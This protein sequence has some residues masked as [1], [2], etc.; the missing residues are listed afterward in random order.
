[1]NSNSYEIVIIGAGPGGIALA[2]ELINKGMGPDK[3]LVLEKANKESWV[4][5]EL[6]PD[7]KLVTANYKGLNPVAKGIMS[8][9]DMSKP[10]ALKALRD[11]IE[12]HNINVEYDTFVS[13]VEKDGENFNVYTNSGIVYCRFAAIGIG[14]FG[15]PNKPGYPIPP[16]IKA[17]TQFDIT[18][19]KIKDANVLVVGGGDSASEYVQHLAMA[20]NRL[21]IS[22][23]QN[24]FSYMNE[25][26]REIMNEM[27]KSDRLIAMRGTDIDG[28]EAFEGKIKVSFKDHVSEPKIFDKIVYAIGGTTPINFLT[29]AG[30][31]IVDNKPTM[32]NGHETSVSNLFLVGDLAVGM[33]G[34]SIILAFNSAESVASEIVN[35]EKR[36]GN[37]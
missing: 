30:M 9:Y 10:D 16:E 2:A 21:T 32:R 31:E 18:S 7:Q 22:S 24:D 13:K 19:V 25:R 26:N 1:M 17:L 28:V 6:Y 35:R 20:G 27:E 14:I 3:I 8:F 34:G 11:T 33:K 36:R 37:Q 12:K 5:R 29:V 15:K 23:R 4:M